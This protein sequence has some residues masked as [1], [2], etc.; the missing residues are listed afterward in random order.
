[1]FKYLL[2]ILFILFSTSLSFAD[3]TAD[4]AEFKRLYAEFN[5][6]Y[7]SSEEIDPIIEVAEKLYKLA[8]KVYGKNHQ[9]TASVTYNLAILYDEKGDSGKFNGTDERKAFDLYEEY[10]NLLDELD[11]PKDELYLNQ[12]I[13]YMVSSFHSNVFHANS[14]IAENMLKIAYDLKI[15]TGDLANYEYLAAILIADFVD[16]DTAIPHFKNTLELYLKELGPGHIRTGGINLILGKH[17]IINKNWEVAINHLLQAA[18]AF[19]KTELDGNELKIDAYGSLLTSYE[20]LGNLEERQK[21][22]ELLHKLNPSVY[23]TSFSP[24]PIKRVPPRYPARAAESG[25]DGYVVVN[26]TVDKEGRT[27]NI[28][29]VDFSDRMFVKPAI[30]AVKKYEYEPPIV[31]GKNIEIHDTTVRI[32]FMLEPTFGAWRKFLPEKLFEF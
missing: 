5:D 21:Y 10:F 2:A 9:N 30:S 29:E 4:K 11:V 8:P 27:K 16:F 23:K 13:R 25:L 32:E 28:K 6:L 19:E 15:N 14:E 20:R 18:T 31:E 17:S 24:V 22:S 3:D 12:Y 26:F 1:M 7:A